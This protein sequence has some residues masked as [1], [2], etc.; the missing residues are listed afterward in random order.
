MTAGTILWRRLDAPGHDACRLEPEPH[1][2]LL[3]G[4][5]VF[6]HDLGPA[7]LSYRVLC[8]A[9]WRTREGQVAG[10]VGAQKI[11]VF[12]SRRPSGVWSLN[13]IYV[14]DLDRC[15]D[16]DLGFTPATNFLQLRRMSLKVGES[17]DIPVAWLDVPAS[18]LE[19]LHQHYER[20][21]DN[22]YWYES[23][24][25]DYRALLE[26]DSVGFIRLYPGLWDAES[27]SL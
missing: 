11:D 10:W 7:C 25:F 4:T 26:T 18:G 15:V 21:T 6:H 22:T 19:V 1:G 2:C 23:P 27:L 24:R 17:A 16:L 14:Q 9:D 5:A 20:R 12:V 3:Y 13:G 8:D